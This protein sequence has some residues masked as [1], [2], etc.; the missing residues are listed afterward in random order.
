[1]FNTWNFVFLVFLILIFGGAI[2]RDAWRD[3]TPRKPWAW[4][5]PELAW[6]ARRVTPQERKRAQV[7][8]PQR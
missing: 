8:F 4:A 2:V 7:E 3:R 1:M 5:P 6:W